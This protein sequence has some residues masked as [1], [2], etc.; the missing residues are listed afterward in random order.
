MNFFKNFSIK[1]RLI[2][3]FAIIL[4]IPTS[5][6]SLLSYNKAKEQIK[7]EQL[8]N[9]E[10]SIHLLNENIS[11]LIDPKLYDANYLSSTL[12][13]KGATEQIH[14]ILA[15]YLATHPEALIAYVGTSE[16]KMIR[17]PY[18]EYDS[19]YDP[20][21]RP[22][23]KQAISTNEAIITTPYISSSSGDLVITIAQKL[24]DG[25]GVFGLD[26]SIETLKEIANTVTIGKNGYVTLLD[27]SKQYISKPN[28]ESATEATESYIEKIFNKQSGILEDENELIAFITNEQTGWKIIGTM[29][30]KEV[31]TA[32]TPILNIIG[33]VVTISFILGSVMVYFIIR[34]ITRPLRLLRSH[35]LQLSEGD[36]SVKIEMDAKNEIGDLAKAFAVM[37]QNLKAVI[38]KVDESVSLV[39]QASEIL[40][41]ST[42]QVIQ[43]TE[44]T[45]N[46]LS[47][48]T[49]LADEQLHSN[50][51]NATSL[52][53][54]V[55][56]V[57]SI[58]E[59]TNDVSGLTQEAMSQ[60]EIGSATVHRSVKQM[61]QIQHSVDETDY[62]VRALYDRTKEI[63]AILSV[64]QGI[65]DQ[66]NLLALNASIEAAR[67]GE[68]GKGFA[69]VAEEV[70]KLAEDSKN[71][72]AQINELIVTIQADTSK[73]V[74]MMRV[75]L[76][77]VNEGIVISNES[78]SRFD[79]IL[80]SMQQITPKILDV[81][82]T[83]QH[84]VHRIQ[85]VTASAELLT[86]KAKEN[87]QSTEEV[88]A[89]SEEVL[90]S[91]EEMAAS[92][93]SL[94]TMSNDLQ[95]TISHF[96]M[97]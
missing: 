78:A 76:T 21:E 91:M 75:T 16:G 48:I 82:S 10:T 52:K 63:N 2:I 49:V 25:S 36:L 88:A 40:A 95:E 93:E 32:A 44:Q 54:V 77:D 60:A 86:E 4:I 38:S 46:A 47:S 14:A 85:E 97:K 8:S 35:A 42:S 65:A 11:A 1:K 89:S 31:S 37:Q 51:L 20:R 9:A 3:A 73:T 56:N 26:M 57:T 53:S 15:D 22:W 59:H 12:I 96:K 62:T 80:T 50:A 70:R 7:T 39:H 79:Q 34:S 66:T 83:T 6:I 43:A 18:Y 90:A 58:A 94:Q 69:V 81:S 17:Q 23:Y 92:A 71:S 24:E 19:S 30:E 33:I 61:A 55:E 84:I 68:H 13:N 67:A 72:T 41:S 28:T 29:L 27:G 87:A 74:D 5:I 45:S 64:I